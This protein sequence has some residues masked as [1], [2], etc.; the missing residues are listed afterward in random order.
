MKISN[1]GTTDQEL[2]LLLS[3]EQKNKTILEAQSASA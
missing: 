2:Q 1:N 3:I